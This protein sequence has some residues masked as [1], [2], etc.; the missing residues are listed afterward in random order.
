ML[1]R[2]LLA[3]LLLAGLPS[4][5]SAQAFNDCSHCPGMTVL[6]GTG[7]GGFAM[8]TAAGGIGIQANE[9]PQH[10]VVIAYRFAVA[11]NDITF[12]DWARCASDHFCNSYNPSDNGWGK[13]GRPVINVSW[14]DAQQYVFWLNTKALAGKGLPEYRLLT[15]AEWEWA[16]RYGQ[17]GAWTYGQPFVAN[18]A[19]CQNCCNP[20]DRDGCATKT[21]PTGR[22]PANNA[23]LRDMSG[24]VAQWVQDC[25][26][27]NYNGAPVNG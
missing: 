16:A 15:E 6:N 7:P 19:N 8:G 11:T 25:Y 23:G 1:V 18:Q 13:G 12:S 9:Q 5:T 17:A 27:T 14:M 26:H 20:V 21:L 3:T 4:M 22:F 24:N 10:N 2:F